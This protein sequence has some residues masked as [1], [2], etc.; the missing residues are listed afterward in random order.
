ME[1]RKKWVLLLTV[2][3]DRIEQLRRV[4]KEGQTVGYT[5]IFLNRREQFDTIRAAILAVLNR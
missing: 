1:E 2:G 5:A 4:G 3:T